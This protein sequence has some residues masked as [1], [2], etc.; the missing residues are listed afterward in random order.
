MSLGEGLEVSY[1]SAVLAEALKKGDGTKFTEI[2]DLIPS[3]EEAEA[4]KPKAVIYSE[5]PLQTLRSKIA[6][7]ESHGVKPLRLSDEKKTETKVMHSS[8]SYDR[9]AKNVKSLEERN[10]FK[11]MSDTRYPCDDFNLVELHDGVENR[12]PLWENMKFMDDD[13]SDENETRKSDSPKTSH[14]ETFQSS[15][16]VTSRNNITHSSHERQEDCRIDIGES[17]SDPIKFDLDKPVYYTDDHRRRLY[18]SSLN[19]KMPKL[20]QSGRSIEMGS[21]NGPNSC[22]MKIDSTWPMGVEDESDNALEPNKKV[23]KKKKK[24][25]KGSVAENEQEKVVSGLDNKKEDTAITEN[26]DEKMSKS[27]RN[28]RRKKLRELKAN[29][30]EQQTFEEADTNSKSIIDEKKVINSGCP[31]QPKKKRTIKQFKEEQQSKMTG[32]QRNKEFPHTLEEATNFSELNGKNYGSLGPTQ[33]SKSQQRKQKEQELREVLNDETM[34][35]ILQECGDTADISTENKKKSKEQRQPLLKVDKKKSKKQKKGEKKKFF[36]QRVSQESDK[37]ERSLSLP[38]EELPVPAEGESQET[39][40]IGNDEDHYHTIQ[41][42]RKNGGKGSLSGSC[43][44]LGSGTR[45]RRYSDPSPTF[46]SSQAQDS[47]RNHPLSPQPIQNRPQFVGHEDIY[48]R[49]SDIQWPTLPTLPDA[50]SCGNVLN[51]RTASYASKLKGNLD[52]TGCSL[53]SSSEDGSSTSSSSSNNC[54]PCSTEAMSPT[55]DH[56]GDILSNVSQILGAAH[57]FATK[58]QQPLPLVQPMPS[59]V[60]PGPPSQREQSTTAA[61]FD[62]NKDKKHTQETPTTKP[63][64]NDSSVKIETKVDIGSHEDGLIKDNTNHSTVVEVEHR[65]M[66][67]LKNEWGLDFFSVEEERSS[68]E[69]SFEYEEDIVLSKENEKQ[70]TFGDDKFILKKIDEP[71]TS[72]DTFKAVNAVELMFPPVEMRLKET[73][74]KW[75]DPGLFDLNKAAIILKNEW[76][77][78]VKQ[79][80]HYE[81]I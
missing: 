33:L 4:A 10:L 26:S 76:Q 35:K 74:T 68:T 44:P 65:V 80:V 6:W 9:K 28:H 34:N 55:S 64:I 12:K 56:H 22:I 38:N 36:E 1:Y 50:G 77:L 30:S 41:R 13:E 61:M 27:S 67:E 31:D 73:L 59:G 14:S 78:A 42:R 53:A 3:K 62:K 54:A 16:S 21:F 20:Q 46:S 23:K 81:N 52:S 25:S 66:L 58:N 79:G 69:Y 47:G 63:A 43:S 75:N 49:E 11:E 32:Q 48:D 15:Q 2:Y 70:L 45:K 71:L 39:G 51:S 5:L 37:E 60:K 18:Q 29:T 7:L 24:K 17:V 72:T 8:S 40:T 57:F 19:E